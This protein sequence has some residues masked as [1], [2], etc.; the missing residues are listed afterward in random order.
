V[1]ILLQKILVQ[2]FDFP[3][4]PN[5]CLR[6]LFVREIVDAIGCDALFL[7]PVW[8]IVSSVSFVLFK[9]IPPN[10]TRADLHK[11]GLSELCRHALAQ[12][13]SKSREILSQIGCHFRKLCP[14]KKALSSWV[15]KELSSP[16][17]TP[18]SPSPRNIL[19]LPDEVQMHRL[20]TQ[21]ELLY[22]FLDH[23]HQR[24]V[25]PHDHGQTLEE[26]DA[27]AR[28][29]FLSHVQEN[30]DKKLPFRDYTPS[31]L[32]ILE[33]G[34][35]FIPD[36][37]ST[38]EGLFSVLIFRG[39][40]YHT[41]FLH[42]QKRIFRHPSDWQELY[43]K[44]SSVHPPIYFCDKNA[45]GQRMDA[46][47]IR[48]IPAFWEASGDLELAG[49][50]KDAR[51]IKF[52][53]LYNTFLKGTLGKRKAFPGFGTLK[54]FL[55]ASDY[56]IARKTT[57]PSPT[58][59]GKIIYE[60]SCGSL[61]GLSCLGFACT[62][63]ESTVQAFTMVHD[64][65]MHAIPDRRRQQMGFGVIFVEYVLCK[66]GRLDTSIFRNVYEKI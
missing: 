62:D 21:I 26:R 66:S 10:P 46:Q 57:M 4:E 54:L 60:I 27:K 11:W 9:N 37:I 14:G 49:W 33:P 25:V 45:Y 12:T 2:W 61:K 7:Q 29:A 1:D 18:R 23:P 8:Q 6:A 13:G 32:R 59:V 56:A 42:Q 5:F 58:L 41:D 64:F 50:V 15:V 28:A 55:L 38:R 47:D 43:K 39:V 65:L 36:A 30:A 3:S 51:P 17:R 16:S 48:H 44:L 22:T 20:V 63:V 31:R 53:T 35:P 19:V 34:G 24:I 40:T 52:E